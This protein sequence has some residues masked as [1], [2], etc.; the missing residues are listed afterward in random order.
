MGKNDR[1]GVTLHT[2]ADV[3]LINFKDFV[4]HRGSLVPV[5]AGRDVP[6]EVRRLFHVRPS[7][8]GITRGQHG[9]FRCTQV[10]ICLS[11][12][13]KVSVEDGTESRS[14]TLD[15]RDQALVI[16]PT[17]WAEETYET[18]D[19]LLLVLCDRPFE[20]DDYIS[21]RDELIALHARR[22]G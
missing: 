14:F 12:S 11:G 8:A 22:A 20:A 16:P 13:C 7:A 2:I 21:D 9:H 17:I 5:E 15:R 18:R 19:T 4:D 10:L 6:I 1:K 3:R